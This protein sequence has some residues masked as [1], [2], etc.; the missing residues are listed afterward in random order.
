MSTGPIVV[1]IGGSLART[2]GPLQRILSL[3]GS[4][5]RGIV[6]VPGGGEFADAVRGA[7]LRFGFDDGAAHRMA[8]LGMHQMGL[9]LAALA[10]ELRA[11]E[12]LEEIAE[13]L[14][15]G[16]N[17]VWLPLRECV[18]DAV[19]PQSWDVT[20]DAIAARLAE[21]LGRL[22]VVFVKSR[23]GGQDRTAAALAAEGLIDAVA[24]RIIETAELPFEAVAAN[25]E[26]RLREIFGVSMQVDVPPGSC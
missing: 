23:S 14:E 16:E 21:R 22:K 20:S 11:C 8:I 17:L 25:E 26:V 6:V 13:G 18:G 15:A 24:A 19:L 7:Q 3:L 4:A 5:R 9:M 12:D 1:K 2:T 10:P